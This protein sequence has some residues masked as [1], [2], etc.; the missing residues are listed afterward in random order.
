MI[1]LPIRQLA[2]AFKLHWFNDN[3][4]RTGEYAV[5]DTQNSGPTTQDN[6]GEQTYPFLTKHPGF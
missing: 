6:Q 2:K 3:L 5:H 1:T 4:P